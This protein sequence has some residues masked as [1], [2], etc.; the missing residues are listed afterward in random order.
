MGVH[1]CSI[2]PPSLSPGSALPRTVPA[3]GPRWCCDATVCLVTLFT[4]EDVLLTIGSRMHA[5]SL[6]SFRQKFSNL[7]TQYTITVNCAWTREKVGKAEKIYA[8]MLADSDSI[9]SL[10]FGNCYFS[11]FVYA[12]TANHSL[13]R[14]SPPWKGHWPDFPSKERRK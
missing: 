4:R 2:P 6:M 5:T 12:Q 9:I 8:F 10:N 13:R 1:G 11:W 14:Q 7:P 3:S